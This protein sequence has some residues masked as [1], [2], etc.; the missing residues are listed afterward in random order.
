[1]AG[2][3]DILWCMEFKMTVLS[4]ITRKKKISYSG[5]VLLCIMQPPKCYEN[6]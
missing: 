2:S 3:V 4:S 5:R 1:M 6:K